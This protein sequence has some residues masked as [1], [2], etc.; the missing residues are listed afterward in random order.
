[1]GI[2]ATGLKVAEKLCRKER[3]A[4]G[5]KVAEKLCRKERKNMCLDIFTFSM[6]N[7]WVI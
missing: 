4:T 2:G 3:K 7:T 1:L 5:L 6:L